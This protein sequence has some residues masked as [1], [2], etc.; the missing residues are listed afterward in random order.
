MTQNKPSGYQALLCVMG[1]I[2]LMFWGLFVLK[3]S[4]H[5]LMVLGICW[6][7]CH[8]YYIDSDVLRL[9]QSMVSAIQKSAG[10]LL[11]FILIGAVIAGFIM[12]GAIPTLIYY[13]LQFIT[14][15][16]FLPIGMLLCSMMSLVIGSCWGTIG[17]MGV[18][19]MG[20][21]VLLHIPAP[22]AA[23]MVVSGAYFGDKFSPISDTTMLSALTTETNLYRHI[24]GMTYSMLPAYLLSLGVFWW[25]GSYYGFEQSLVLSDVE[26]LRQKIST[27]FTIHYV[28]LAPM[29]GMLWLSIKKKPA[30][31][32][33]LVSIFVAILVAVGIQK[34][35]MVAVLDSLFCGPALPTTGSVILDA[36]LKHGGIQS[37]LWSMS[38][39]LLI[40]ILGGLLD[41]YQL[42][43]TLFMRLLPY[44]TRPFRLVATT[45]FAAIACNV[46]MGEAYLSIILNARIFKKT[47]TTMRWDS[48][49]LSKAI[50]VG[51][52]LSTPLIP[53]TSSGVFITATLGI[54][55][56]DYL[57]WALFNWIALGVFFS[58]AAMNFMGIK[59]YFNPKDSVEVDQ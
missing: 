48:C 57:Q 30:E 20:I 12:S 29:L 59:M 9:K 36:V 53:W 2:S 19:L 15:Q 8:A 33:M 47:Y 16:N 31:L 38:L 37:M 18:A 51:S 1:I 7:V 46:L 10:V 45:V 54:S 11:F 50:E 5:S 27:H 44:L 40:L 4:L 24:K 26:A 13:G 56:Q 41:S 58:M 17:T 39:T 21:A 22:I 6:V 25:I 34:F 32:S 14:P 23:G 35:S 49:V 28:T 3:A 43:A 52:T 55:P 42:I